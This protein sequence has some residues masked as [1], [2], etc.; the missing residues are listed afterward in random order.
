M[1]LV[2]RKGCFRRAR[3]IAAGGGGVRPGR[4]V[5]RSGLPAK[6]PATDRGRQSRRVLE[7]DLRERPGA[8]HEEHDADAREHAEVPADAEVTH[9]DERAAQAVDAVRQRI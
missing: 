7:L 2:L 9:A 8:E 5:A 4:T 6:P 1:L 3:S